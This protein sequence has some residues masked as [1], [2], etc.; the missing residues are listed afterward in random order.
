[1]LDSSKPPSMTSDFAPWVHAL[2]SLIIFF[3]AFIEHRTC[4]NNRYMSSQSASLTPN[5]HKSKDDL[6]NQ[7]VELLTKQEQVEV[8]QKMGQNPSRQQPALVLLVQWQ[9]KSLGVELL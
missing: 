7:W 5:E 1:M 8:P 9:A 6:L 2:L 4:T 3:L